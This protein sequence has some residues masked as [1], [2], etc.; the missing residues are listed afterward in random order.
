MEVPRVMAKQTSDITAP[1]PPKKWNQ[2]RPGT[3]TGTCPATDHPPARGVPKK[4]TP[5][6]ILTDCSCP[7]FHFNKPNESPRLKFH[8]EVGWPALENHG[9]VCEKDL[10]EVATIIY[11][12]NSRFP[13]DQPRGTRSTG[14]CHA[15]EDSGSEDT[16]ST[17]WVHSPSMPPIIP[18]VPTLLGHPVTPSTPTAPD[19]LHNPNQVAPPPSLKSFPDL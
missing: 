18:V 10:T 2:T 14:S 17:K 4:Y 9:Y 12:F 19:F 8:Q 15:T 1:P 16:T 6:I 13:K 5:E 7:G 3:P 11:Q